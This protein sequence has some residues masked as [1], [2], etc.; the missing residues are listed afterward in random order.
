MLIL[1]KRNILWLSCGYLLCFII[2]YPSIGKAICWSKCAN[3]YVCQS[4]GEVLFINLKIFSFPLV[5]FA[6]ALVLYIKTKRNYF[7]ITFLI[8]YSHLI[9]T[10]IQL[11]ETKTIRYEAV[12]G[13]LVV[14]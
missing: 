6:L 5:V 14:D 7:V 11:A 4:F 8:V 12:C 9:L 10:S 2:F 13:R 1:N 3:D